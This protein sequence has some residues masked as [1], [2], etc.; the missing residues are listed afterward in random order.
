MGM[1]IYNLD[2]VSITQ[3]VHDAWLAYLPTAVAQLTKKYPDLTADE[4]PDEHFAVHAD[5]KGEIFV[6][7]RSSRIA[8]SVLKDEY[9]IN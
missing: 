6:K 8:M 7:I 2:R 4:I 1:K 5:G 3:R 9:Q